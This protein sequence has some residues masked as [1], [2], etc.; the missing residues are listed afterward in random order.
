MTKTM[1]LIRSEV[2]RVWFLCA[3]FVGAG[4]TLHCI[5][6]VWPRT[7][8]WYVRSV[9]DCRCSRCYWFDRCA[10]SFWT[11]PH[12]FVKTYLKLTLANLIVELFDVKYYHDLE[13]WVRDH[14]RSLKV[15]PFESLGTVSYSPSIVTMAVSAAIWRYLA[16]KNG[17][18]LKSGFGVRQ[19]H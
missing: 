17:L 14:S 11:S 12:R 6:Y 5:I 2:D 15:V 1:Q 4:I 8:H 19:N 7:N 9:L 16:S 10:R 18:A 3:S 13:M